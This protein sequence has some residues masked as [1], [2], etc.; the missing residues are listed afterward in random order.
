MNTF[1]LFGH[2]ATALPCG[3]R[4]LCSRFSTPAFFPPLSSA[5][6]GAAR[7]EENAGIFSASRSAIIASIDHGSAAVL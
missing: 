3:V 4:E 1:S 5:R 7:F 6:P 2:G